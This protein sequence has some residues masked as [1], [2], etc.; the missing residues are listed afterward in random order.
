MPDLPSLLQLSL[1]RAFQLWKYEVFFLSQGRL[2]FECHLPA[3]DPSDEL[4]YVALEA[5]DDEESVHVDR[6][7]GDDASPTPDIPVTEI[8]SEAEIEN[9]VPSLSPAALFVTELPAVPPLPAANAEL[10]WRRKRDVTFRDFKRSQLIDL[11]ESP[12]DRL[13]NDLAV[14]SALALPVT[15][16]EIVN[17]GFAECCS[18]GEQTEAEART[19]Y[20]STDFG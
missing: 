20:L 19:T 3:F 7:L 18:G 5:Q 13:L 6:S 11:V 17:A 2:P 1:D 12:L 8:R 4:A 15:V 16:E 14:S 10:V 9:S